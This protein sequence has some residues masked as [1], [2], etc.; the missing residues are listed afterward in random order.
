MSKYKIFYSTNGHETVVEAPSKYKAIEIFENLKTPN[1]ELKK[2][3]YIYEGNEPLKEWYCT[4]WNGS[5]W[6]SKVVLAHDRQEI[7][8]NIRDTLS[9]CVDDFDFCENNPEA[10]HKMY[11]SRLDQGG[12]NV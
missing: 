6:Q 11:A 12:N 2:C 7:E 1:A 4:W 8:D 3:R 10:I 5:Y 9:F